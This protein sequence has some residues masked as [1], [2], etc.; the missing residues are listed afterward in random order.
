MS[1][2]GDGR[3][4]NGSTGAVTPVAAPPAAA[5]ATIVAPRAEDATPRSLS[6]FLSLADFE[7]AARRALPRQIYGYYAGAAETSQSFQGNFAAFRQYDLVPRV[8]TD[9][10]SRSTRAKLFGMDYWAP[11]G[12]APM[13][14]SGLATF[15]GEIA[16]A[17]AASAANIPSIVSATSLTPL[18]RIA[19]E[20][21][22][23]WFQAYLPGED[24]R[25]EAMVARVQAAGYDTF[26]L[27]A[28]VP[29]AANRENNVRT[30]FSIP[31]QPSLRL[32]WDGL[33][34]PRWLCR[35]W[36]ATLLSRGVPH[37]ENMDAFRG[38]PILARNV[39]RAIGARDQLAWRHLALIR[40]LWP[41]RLVVKG[42]LSP[43][44]AVLAREN[45]A[46]GIIVSNH[47]GRQLDG[48]R[49]PLLA[50]PEIAEVSGS[51]AVML[52]GGIR[53]GSDV[54]KAL[55]LGADFVFVGRP[56]LFAAA[57]RGEAGVSHAIALLVAEIERNMALLGVSRIEDVGAAHVERSPFPR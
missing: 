9:V 52:D 23:R 57:A 3:T 6:R 50:L 40:R 12:I 41:G 20:G 16:L 21:R 24:A 49:P 56:F 13:G 43:A 55:A 33:S 1:D 14:L 44:D 48:A 39:V 45:G 10:S 22:A 2:K 19:Q 25:I 32:A 47:G 28:D 46:D 5:P 15:D 8:L 42:I 4:A 11:F 31:L 54:L 30:G 34:H 38:P 51:M 18:E 36:F 27:T 35:T 53:R 26:V 7:T 29:V 17:R 37:F